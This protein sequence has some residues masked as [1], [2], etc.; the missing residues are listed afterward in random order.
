MLKQYKYL[1]YVLSRYKKCNVKASKFKSQII[2]RFTVILLDM[3]HTFM[4]NADRFSD[5][6]DYGATYYR[7]GGSFLN[8][9]EVH[10]IISTLFDRMR[11]DYRFFIVL[12]P[13]FHSSPGG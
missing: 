3:C 4:F 5:S 12:I 6:E 10:R 7:I 8:K 11:F 1:S 2:D 9:R 13:G